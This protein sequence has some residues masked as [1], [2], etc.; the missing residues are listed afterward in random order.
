MLYLSKL[1]LF[2]ITKGGTIMNMQLI[3]YALE[4]LQNVSFMRKQVHLILTLCLYVFIQ[5]RMRGAVAQN[6]DLGK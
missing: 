1:K 3:Q 5:L 6:T 4:I 2:M